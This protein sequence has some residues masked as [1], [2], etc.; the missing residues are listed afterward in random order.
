MEP[1]RGLDIP[2]NVKAA[3]ESRIKSEQCVDCSLERSDHLM[4]GAVSLI[5]AVDALLKMSGDKDA[6]EQGRELSEKVMQDFTVPLK[7]ALFKAMVEIQMLRMAGFLTREK[8]IEYLTKYKKILDSFQRCK[9]YI[10][11]DFNLVPLSDYCAD[12]LRRLE[13]PY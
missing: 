6:I 5:E 7:T 8:E 13:A 11:R 1:V 2:N 3:A 4:A 9:Q 10:P 12:R